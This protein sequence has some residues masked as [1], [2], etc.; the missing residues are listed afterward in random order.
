M[1]QT[2][3]PSWRFC[4]RQ[5]KIYDSTTLFGFNSQCLQQS[6]DRT[7]SNIFQFYLRCSCLVATIF[8]SQARSFWMST[9]CL[10]FGEYWEALPLHVGHYVAR[11]WTFRAAVKCGNLKRSILSD[12]LQSFLFAEVTA[13][14]LLV[15]V[16]KPLL[17]D[18]PT[19]S[20]VAPGWMGGN[21]KEVLR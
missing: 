8:G 15:E 20:G 16:L 1:K 14:L 7:N 2:S 5:G 19:D 9:R 18:M 10:F 17:R 6:R 4:L 21:W 12:F 11:G 13:P 3:W